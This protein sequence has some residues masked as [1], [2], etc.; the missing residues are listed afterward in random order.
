MKMPI[1]VGLAIAGLTCF[2]SA[3]CSLLGCGSGW[4]FSNV[5]L[6]IFCTFISLF[7]WRSGET[8][9][10]S[11]AIGNTWPLSAIKT[12]TFIHQGLATIRN[13]FHG[14]QVSADKFLKVVFS[15]QK[16]ISTD[17]SNRRN[18]FDS[19]QTKKQDFY[20]YPDK[21]IIFIFFAWDKRF[22]KNYFMV[23]KTIS[24]AERNPE[25]FSVFIFQF[26]SDNKTVFF[27][28]TQTFNSK[29]NDESFSLF[30]LLFSV[31]H[32]K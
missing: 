17:T 10:E 29:K 25:V 11:P 4:K 22:D 19:E 30:L 9:I 28:W 32:E 12:E 8:F 24:G 20:F 2:L 23:W 21:K 18:F 1:T 6:F 27:C 31:W 16:N 7:G 15:W 5:L 14:W 3:F 13:L 26:S